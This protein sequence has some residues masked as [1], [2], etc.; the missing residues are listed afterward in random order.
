M[1]GSFPPTSLGGADG[2][3]PFSMISHHP[4]P[5]ERQRRIAS[6]DLIFI[7]LSK[8]GEGCVP[9]FGPKRSRS[10]TSSQDTSASPL[11]LVGLNRAAT[12]KTW[13]LV[14]ASPRRSNVTL[15]FSISS[16]EK[17]TARMRPVPGSSDSSVRI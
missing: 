12:V 16:L 15:A 17:V 5:M 3:P 13:V 4:A 8:R 6:F 2:T 14:Y 10:P 9:T 7:S 1:G 11:M